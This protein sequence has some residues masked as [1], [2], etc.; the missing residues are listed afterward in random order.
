MSY[1]KDIIWNCFKYQRIMKITY[2]CSSNND[3]SIGY[4]S[5]GIGVGAF[6]SRYI[7]YRNIS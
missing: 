1:I 5:I 6:Y 3:E 4:I 7:G 2:I